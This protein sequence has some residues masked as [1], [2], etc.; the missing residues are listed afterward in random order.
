MDHIAN[1]IDAHS[2]SPF[3]LLSHLPQVKRAD[4]AIAIAAAA[5]IPEQG[6]QSGGYS[7]DWSEYAHLPLLPLYSEQQQALLEK[8]M[9][10]KQRL[11]RDMDKSDPDKLLTGTQ[12]A[13]LGVMG[14]LSG[15][16]NTVSVMRFQRRLIGANVASS[17]LMMKQHKRIVFTRWA[18]PGV[19]AREFGVGVW[20]VDV[21][22][23]R[24]VES[25]NKLTSGNVVFVKVGL[26]PT[27]GLKEV[28]L[29]LLKTE[30]KGLRSQ[31]T[32]RK[33][34][35]S[36][37]CEAVGFVEAGG[38]EVANGDCGEDPEGL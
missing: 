34:L 36:E 28:S 19:A 26:S 4:K 11:V 29:R 32:W 3:S 35:N 21:L 13:L 33:A 7:E 5:E 15:G 8:Q 18:V 22:E 14:H 37:K 38:R 10:R 30:A 20:F 31:K 17:N 6:E 12:K 25:N 9:D 16:A 24:F 2:P 1:A 23:H 27:A